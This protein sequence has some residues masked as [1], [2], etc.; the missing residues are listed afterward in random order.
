MPVHTLITHNDWRKTLVL[1]TEPI[2]NT[3]WIKNIVCIPLTNEQVEE[4]MK[5]KI[6]R[7]QAL[8]SKRY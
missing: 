7:V 3:Y 1:G 6:E 8:L 5:A 2:E 4:I